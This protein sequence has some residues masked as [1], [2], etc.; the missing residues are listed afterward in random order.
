MKIVV[1]LGNPGKE[2]DKTYH[3]IGFM[4]VDKLAKKMGISVNKGKFNSLYGMGKLGNEIVVIVKPLTY[5]NL[6]G[7]AVKSFAKFYKV[8]P[9]DIF[10]FCDDIDLE[11]GV[12]RF[13]EHGSGGTHNGLKNI[14]WELGSENFRRIKI[15]AGNDKSIDLKDYVLSKIDEESLEKIDSAIDEGIEK[16]LKFVSSQNN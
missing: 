15:G 1:G 5:M 11:K 10:V 12:A 2:Y 7:Q 13:K 3:N 16:F 9:E 8:L 14:V 4:A 6:S